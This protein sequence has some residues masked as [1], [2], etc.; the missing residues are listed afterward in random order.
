M[1]E[2]AGWLTWVFPFIG[3]ALTPI[4]V[5]VSP[6]LRNYGAI[7]FSLLGAVSALLLIPT[8]FYQPPQDLQVNWI[9][10]VGIKVKRPQRHLWSKLSDVL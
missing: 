2:A 7:G 1:F 3:A 9:Q 6:K 5:R 8:A 10:S 4:M